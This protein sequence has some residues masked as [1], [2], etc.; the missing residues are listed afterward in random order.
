MVFISVTI[1]YVTSTCS[2]EVGR[3]VM[4]W[5][6]RVYPLVMKRNGWSETRSGIVEWKT[7]DGSCGN[8]ALPGWAGKV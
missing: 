2:K 4:H 7:Q 5:S 1:I 3:E 8:N 6:I